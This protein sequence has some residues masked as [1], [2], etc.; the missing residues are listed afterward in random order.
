MEYVGMLPR[1]QKPE[2]TEGYEGFIH[3][4][5]IHGDVEHTR[6]EFIVRDHDP[7]LFETKKQVMEAAA[8]YLNAKYPTKPVKLTLTDSYRNMKEQILPHWEVIETMEK[9]MRANGVEPCA[10]PIRGGTDG[11]RLSYMGLP[12][13]N[14]CTGSANHHGKLEYAVVEDME[15]VKDIIKTAIESID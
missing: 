14:L 8:T 5:S 9:A 6:M 1:E 3:L 12:C 2:Y 11:A 7:A 13:P 15:K 10:I 4:D